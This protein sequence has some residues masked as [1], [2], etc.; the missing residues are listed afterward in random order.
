MAKGFERASGYFSYFDPISGRHIEGETR[1]CVHCGLTWIYDP[2]EDMRR[3]LGLS[4]LK[5][6]LRGTCMRCHG[7]VCAMPDCMKAGCKTVE[8]KIDELEKSTSGILVA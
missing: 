6:T 3:K 4:S 5:P 7:L 1:C 8:E 2:A